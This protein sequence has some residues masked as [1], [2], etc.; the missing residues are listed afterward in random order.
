[1]LAILVIVEVGVDAFVVVAVDVSSA[2]VFG[3]LTLVGGAALAHAE[4]GLAVASGAAI[5]AVVLALSWN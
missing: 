3:G 5:C 1:M 4:A 2:A